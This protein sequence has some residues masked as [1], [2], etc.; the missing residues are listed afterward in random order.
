VAPGAGE[1]GCRLEIS[2][3]FSFRIARTAQSTWI[4]H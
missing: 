2:G 1:I 3:H 4:G